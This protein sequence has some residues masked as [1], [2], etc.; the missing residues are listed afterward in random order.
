MHEQIASAKDY[1]YLTSL[2]WQDDAEG[3]ALGRHVAAAKLN[4]TPERLQGRIKQGQ[5]IREIRNHRLSAAIWRRNRIAGTTISRRQAV[6]KVASMSERERALAV[7]REIKKLDVRIY[8][9]MMPQLRQLGFWRLLSPALANIERVGGEV[10]MAHSPLTFRIPL[11]LRNLWSTTSHAKLLLTPGE[12]SISGFNVG[13]EYYQKKGPLKWHDVGIHLQGDVANTQLRNFA[14]HWAREADR[15]PTRA[16]PLLFTG[17]KRTRVG[18]QR[19]IKEDARSLEN[20]RLAGVIVGSD[21]LSSSEKPKF[22]E[23]AELA[24]AL[25]TFKESFVTTSPYLTSTFFAERALAT[26]KRRKAQGKDAGVE[27]ILPA[28]GFDEWTSDGG[29]AHDLT[30]QLKAAGAKIHHWA[31]A[32][33][34]RRFKRYDDNAFIHAKVSQYDKKVTKVSSANKNRRSLERDWETGFVTRS[35][36]IAQ[37]VL[38]RVIEPTIAQSTP[39]LLFPNTWW[40]RAMSRVKRFV[41][42][43]L[44]KLY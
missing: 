39:M 16:S 23:R 10:L 15:S 37:E 22:N 9:S 30:A 18:A 31:P 19:G 33:R 29:A 7:G 35:R 25:A 13:D 34:R 27:L 8:L 32:Q 44:G 26:V 11:A 6:Q 17:L 42:G 1:F 2:V 20:P 4:L 40:H 3:R 21:D 12:V 24:Y 14:R 43:K 41:F 28:Q 38:H 5:S 36:H